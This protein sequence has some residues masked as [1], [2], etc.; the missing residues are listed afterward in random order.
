MTD[1]TTSAENSAQSEKSGRTS[2]VVMS[3]MRPTGK[4]HLGHY[5]GVL[6]NWLELQ[7]THACYFMVADWHALTTKY[8]STDNLKQDIID[9]SLDWLAAGIDPGKATLYVQSSLP[10]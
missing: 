2:N 5:M 3:G 1:I 10:E 4:L 8:D 7:D 6:R 9:M